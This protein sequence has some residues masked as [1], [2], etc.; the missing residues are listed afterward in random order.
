MDKKNKRI[1]PLADSRE[2]VSAADKIEW[3][4]MDGLLVLGFFVLVAIM[5]CSI[6]FHI[7]IMTALVFPLTLVLIVFI[8]TFNYAKTLRGFIKMQNQKIKKDKTG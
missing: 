4:G 2:N 7:D 6:K 8:V 5:F 1:K 3:F